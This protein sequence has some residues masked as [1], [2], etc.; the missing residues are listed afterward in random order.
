MAVDMIFNGQATGDVASALLTNGFSANS[1]RPYIGTDG[2]SYIS[3]MQ[4]GKLV[5]QRLAMNTATLRKDDWKVLD[6]VVIKAA[7]PRLRAVADLRSRGLQFTIPNGMGKTVLESENVSD[8]SDATVTMDGLENGANDR[9]VFS[10]VNLPLPIIHKNFSFSLRQIE[11]S[12]NSSTPLDM[13]GAELASRRVAEQAEKM[14]IGTASDFAFAGANVYGYLNFPNRIRQLITSPVASGWTAAT[15]VA[16]VLAMQTASINAFHYGPWVLYYGPAWSLYMNSEYKAESN[17]TLAQRLKRIEGVED[18]R[19]LDYLTGYDLVMVQMTSD[20]VR[21]VVGMDIT[22]LQWDSMGGLK[23]NFKVMAIMVP[24]L[25]TDHN[26][27]TGI[28][29]GYTA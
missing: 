1:L 22:S 6:S 24:Q 15:T 8:I 7:K 29:H 25:R 21:E 20:V 2:A 18:V 9:P 12:R 26:L 13:T 11:A 3:T 14:L 5:P 16:N 17:D 4:D 19:M 27:K 23:K 10:L 28:V